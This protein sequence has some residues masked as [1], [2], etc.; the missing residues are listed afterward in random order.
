MTDIRLAEVSDPN[1]NSV[2]QLE[3]RHTTTKYVCLGPSWKKSA[4][5]ASNGYVG[6]SGTC[7]GMAGLLG[8]YLEHCEHD[9]L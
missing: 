1:L 9:A 8:A 5:I 7:G 6:S 2:I 4:Q 3:K